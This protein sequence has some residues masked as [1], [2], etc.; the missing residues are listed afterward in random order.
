M[1]LV[2]KIL[3]TAGLLGAACFLGVL[4]LGSLCQKKGLFII[5]QAADEAEQI[6]EDHSGDIGL[7]PSALDPADRP[8]ETVSNVE[9][10]GGLQANSSA[11]AGVNFT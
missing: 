4:Y 6:V 9:A 10:G 3:G 5:V 11:P 7:A 1:M 8:C 2:I